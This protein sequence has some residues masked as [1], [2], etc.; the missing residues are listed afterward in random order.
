MVS[1]VILILSLLIASRDL[2]THRISNR[3]NLLFA[4]V[5]L[6]DRHSLGIT[7]I[8]LTFL[9][10]LVLML[11]LRCGMGDVKLSLSLLL[12]QS[13]IICTV[14]YLTLVTVTATLTLLVALI[15]GSRVNGSIAF[16][17]A[18]V[19]PFAAIYLAI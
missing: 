12:S 1:G 5:L 2:R 8:A 13:A 17:P 11:A 15:C 10:T 14:Q 9:A 6:L 16:A 4:L 18:L 7:A 3:L 19:L